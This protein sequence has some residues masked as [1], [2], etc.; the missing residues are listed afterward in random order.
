M[1]TSPRW[2]PALPHPLSGS[3]HLCQHCRHL[4]ELC[5]RFRLS[6]VVVRCCLQSSPALQVR[7]GGQRS[8]MMWC[9]SITQP[10]VERSVLPHR[11]KLPQ[12]TGRR[13]WRGAV[14]GARKQLAQVCSRRQCVPP[15]S[16]PARTL[17]SIS[18]NSIEHRGSQARK[19]QGG[20]HWRRAGSRGRVRSS[21]SSS[22]RSDGG[23]PSMESSSSCTPLSPP[24]QAPATD[25]KYLTPGTSGISVAKASSARC[26]SVLH[27]QLESRGSEGGGGDDAHGKACRPVSLGPSR[28][29]PRR[30]LSRQPLFSRAFNSR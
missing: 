4:G 16:P 11:S 27:R 30:R 1:L 14:G 17:G 3:A 15:P 13:R 25:R 24:P 5:L 28:R 9:G 6:N 10:T 20:V 19:L 2:L 8:H 21:S 12:P 22:P 29:F 7:G 23:T 18:S 26:T